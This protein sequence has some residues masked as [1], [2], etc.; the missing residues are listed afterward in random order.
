[1]RIK[2]LREKKL[3]PQKELAKSMNVAP[4]T[5]AMWE[6]GKRQ[7]RADKLPE[8]ARVLGCTIDDLYD[9]GA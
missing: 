9:K 1:M 3:I 4:S 6:S 7:P 5:M 8:L 2:D